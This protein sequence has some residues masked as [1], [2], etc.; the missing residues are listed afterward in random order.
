TLTAYD[1]DEAEARGV[2]QKVT[3]LMAEGVPASEI[4]VL[5]RTN[6]QSEAIESALAQA[7][8]PYLV[9]GGARFFS[10]A[11]VR[12]AVLL[13]RGAVRSDDG[14]AALGEIVRGVLSGAGWSPDPPAG[15]GATRER[16]ESL[17]AIAVLADDLARST[18]GARTADLVAELDRRSSEQHAPTV[19]GIT[20]ASLHAAKGLEWDA[21]LLIGCSEGLLPITLADGPA[22]VEEERRLLYVGVTR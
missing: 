18:P 9:R 2:A 22:R 3:T 14:S 13:L 4:A 10:R 5:Y 15:G 20:L 19:Q 21:V 6:S 11:E 8:V 16:W 1:D 17:Q 7:G 12:S